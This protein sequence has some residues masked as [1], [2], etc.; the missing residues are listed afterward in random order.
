TGKHFVLLQPGEAGE[1]GA[2]VVEDVIMV[3]GEDAEH[4]MAAFEAVFV[5]RQLRDDELQVA[6]LEAEPAQRE[7]FGE[8]V[9]TAIA[10]A[11]DDE[12]EAA[13][14]AILAAIVAMLF[15]MER[16]EV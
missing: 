8:R 5:S 15:V 9:V 2:T 16:V 6:L 3:G 1:I 10:L 7:V 11:L 13:G 4:H 14:P 12:L